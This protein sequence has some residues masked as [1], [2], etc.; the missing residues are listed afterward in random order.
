MDRV[1]AMIPDCTAKRYPPGV[2][3]GDFRAVAPM[4]VSFLDGKGV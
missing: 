1:A 4:F 2:E 3:P